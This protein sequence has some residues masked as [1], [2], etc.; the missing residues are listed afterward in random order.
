MQT[1]ASTTITAKA[2][3]VIR[4]ADMPDERAEA[5][6]TEAFDIYRDACMLDAIAQWDDDERAAEKADATWS[7]FNHAAAM[8]AKAL[9]VSMRQLVRVL[10]GM[11]EVS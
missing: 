1:T 5:L 4:S 7:E 6:L 10:E 11:I 3:E 2:A 8:T 9:G